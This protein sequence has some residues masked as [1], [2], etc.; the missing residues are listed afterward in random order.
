M[1]RC[2][3][4]MILF[5]WAKVKRHAKSKKDIILIISSITWPYDLPTKKQRSLNKFYDMQFDGDSFLL[6][7]ELLLQERA[8]SN[9]KIVEY[10]TLAARRSY[11]EYLYGRKRTLDCRLAPFIPTDNELLTV[12]NS[13]IYFAFE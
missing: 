5:D 2:G 10:I 11:A 9:F 13:Q 12:K 8:L 3:T 6:H 1:I 4:I 7:P